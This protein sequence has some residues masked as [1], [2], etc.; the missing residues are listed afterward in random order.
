M[1]GTPATDSRLPETLRSAV[2]AA[3]DRKARDLRAL[4]LSRV[5]DFTDY[6]V[7]CSGRSERQVGAIAEGVQEALAALGVKPLHVEGLP[8]A[9]WVLL[10]YGDIVVHVFEE[11]TRSFY[12]LEKLW[13]DAPEVTAEL[14]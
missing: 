8:A 12:G 9:R 2:A 3:E 14:H 1:T 13:S 11:E 7:V 4:D 6:F 5:S 10:D